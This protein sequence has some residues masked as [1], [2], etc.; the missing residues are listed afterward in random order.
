MYSGCVL[1]QPEYI[2]KEASDT[3]QIDETAATD[4]CPAIALLLVD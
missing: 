1:P 4:I 2:I 3:H